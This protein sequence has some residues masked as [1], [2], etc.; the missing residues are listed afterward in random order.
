MF[1]ALAL[2]QSTQNITLLPVHQ[3]TVLVETY[4]PNH[5]PNIDVLKNDLVKKKHSSYH[6]TIA[7]DIELPSPRSKIGRLACRC[8]A[9]VAWIHKKLLNDRMF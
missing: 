2:H 9:A 1:Q 7:M 8:G 3:E 6:L 5:R 4:K